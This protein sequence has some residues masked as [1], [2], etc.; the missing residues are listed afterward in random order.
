MIQ[1]SWVANF[2]PIFLFA[3]LLLNCLNS[4]VLFDFRCPRPQ[5]GLSEQI[6]TFFVISAATF[7]CRHERFDMKLSF[8]EAQ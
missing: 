6:I 8:S 7:G 3:K 4:L 1:V 2:D 5:I